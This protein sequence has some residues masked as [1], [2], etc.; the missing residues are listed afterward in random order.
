VS[1]QFAIIINDGVDAVNGTFAGYGEGAS[2][3]F[4]NGVELFITYAGNADGGAV[5]N[6]V[7]LTVPEPGS[8]TLLIGGLAMLLGRRR[9]KQA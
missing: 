4:F 2:V 8:A 9:R 6:D 5:G 1:D 3:G 7:L